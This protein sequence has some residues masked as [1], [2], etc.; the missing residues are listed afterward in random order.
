MIASGHYG[1]CIDWL[2]SHDVMD[3]T[4]DH[5]TGE[6]SKLLNHPSAE[7]LFAAMP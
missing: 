4:F 5:E 1:C 7:G 3:E 6:L 2:R